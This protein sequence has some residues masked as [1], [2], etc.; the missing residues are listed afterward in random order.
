MRPAV[1]EPFY[2][3]TEFEITRHPHYGRFLRLEPGHLIELTWMTESPG[4]A[5]AET[6]IRVE[7]TRKG[8]RTKLRLT[9]GGFRNDEAAARHA[10]A[11]RYLH[12][13][14]AA[15]FRADGMMF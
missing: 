2:F 5:G 9:H 3:Q 12:T 14:F 7:L 6:V 11:I 1:D 8:D 10:S 4:T 13:R 15:Y